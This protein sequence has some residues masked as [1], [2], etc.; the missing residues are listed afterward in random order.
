MS[1]KVNDK[2]FIRD[3]FDNIYKTAVSITKAYNSEYIPLN[4]LWQLLE[5]SK[6]KKN[7]KLKGFDVAYNKTVDTLYTTSMKYCETYDL[8]KRLPMI[9]F[10]KYISVVKENI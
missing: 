3:Q 8:H 5:K 1:I 9:V 7:K 2:E 4:L 6:L 10:K